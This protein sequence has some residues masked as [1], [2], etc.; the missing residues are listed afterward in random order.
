MGR[1]RHD[2]NVRQLSNADVTGH[3]LIGS[4]AGT[5]SEDQEALS[6]DEFLSWQ[7]LIDRH[8]LPGRRATPIPDYRE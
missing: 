1:A 2:G 5:S 3:L 8:G 4:A 6:V 7:H